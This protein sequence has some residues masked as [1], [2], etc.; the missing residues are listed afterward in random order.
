[1]T[2]VEARAAAGSGE[3]LRSR[4]AQRLARARQ[5]GS[6]PAI[7]RRPDPDAPV[8]LSGS[9][10]GMWFA[11]QYEPESPAYNVPTGLRLR[12]PLDPESLCGAV[13][14]LVGRH[15][16]LRSVVESSGGAPVCVPRPAGELRV[17]VVDL[18]TQECPEA[19]VRDRLARCG[20]EPFALDRDLPTRAVLYRLADDDHLLALTFH[21]IA[22]DAWS[23][24]LI[25]TDL[26]A[27]YAVRTGAAAAVPPAPLQYAD[28]LDWERRRAD[29]ARS[30]ATLNWWRERLAGLPAVLPLPADRPRPAVAESAGDRVPVEL[31]AEFADR[32]RRAAAETGSTPFM[33]LLAAW[34]A[35]LARLAGTDD[36]AVGMISAGRRHPE[37]EPV[38]GCFVR[39]VP[40]RAELSGEP[41][42]RELLARTRTAVL[43][44]I[45]H[46]DVSLE[47]LLTE[48]RPERVAGAHPLFQTLVNVYDDPLGAVRLPGLRTEAVELDT[49]TAKLD[50]SLNVVDPGPGRPLPGWLG[51]RSALFDRSTVRALVGWFTALLGGLVADLDR[52]VPAVPLAPVPG[53]LLTGPEPAW[54]DDATTLTALV[55]RRIAERPAAPAV[56]GPDGVLSYAELD[57]RAELLARRLRTAGVG[58]DEPVAVWVERSTDL[59]VGLL[60]ALRA[61]AAYL[62]LDPGYPTARVRAMLA[63]VRGRVVVTQPEL[64]ARLADDPGGAAGAGL[65]SV[66]LVD[67]A[68]DGPAPDSPVPPGPAL[69]A[70]PAGSADGT[71]AVGTTDEADRLAYVIFTSGST[72]TPKG[73]AVSHRS[74]VHYL[75]AV[76][77]RL[78]PPASGGASFALVSTPAADLGLTCL[79]GALVTGGTLHLVDRE[80]SLDP[81]ALAGYLGRHRVDVLKLVP[82]Q[83]RLLDAHGD[84]AGVLPGRLLV[85]AGEACP[86]ELVARVRAARPDLAVQSH[87]GPT[88]TT[89]AVLACDPDEVPESRRDG[90]LPLGRPLAGARLYV[91][92]RAGRPLPAGVPGEL[93]V[94]GPGV[95]RGYLHRP[96]A[97]AASFVP[98]PVHGRERCY[99]TGDRVRIRPDGTVDFLGRVDDQVKIRGYRVEPGEVAAACRA[100]P[101]VADAYVLPVGEEPRRQLAAWLVRRPDAE[102]DVATVRTALHGQL[103]DHLI[104]TAYVVLDA[105]PLN[106]N[107]KVDRAALPAPVAAGHTPLTGDTQHRI[108]AVWTGLLGAGRVGADDDF[109]ALG[110]DSFTAVRAARAI[111][112]RLRVI[113]LFTHR[114]VALLAR[115]LDGLDGGAEAGLLHRLAGPPPGTATT[116]TAVCVPYGGGSAAALQPFA[117][118]LAT[119][120]PGTQVYAVELPGHDPARPDEPLLPLPDLVRRCAAELD[121]IPGPLLV[122]GHCVGTAAALA[123]AQRLERDGREVVGL[124]LGA[125]FPMARLPGRLSRWIGR[126]FPTDR[127]FS[128]RAYRNFLTVMGGLEDV[129]DTPE[130]AADT[131]TMLRALRHDARDA[132]AWFSDRLGDPDAPRLRAPVLAVVGERDRSTELYAERYREWGAF[133]E[134]VELATIPRAGHYFLKHQAAGLGDLVAARLRAWGTGELPAAG[135]AE[136]LARAETRRNLRA[137]GLLAGGQFVSMVGSQL[138][139]FALGVWVY[140]QTGRL[141]DFAMITM[142]ALVPAVFAAPIGGAVTDRFDRRRV[143]LGADL[144][145][146]VAMGALALQ[147]W[148]GELRIWQVMLAVTVGSLATAVQRPAYLAATAQLVPKPYLPQANALANLGTGVGTLL[149]PLAGGVLITALG[150]PGVV[151]LDV[152]CFLVAVGTL[153]VVRFPD[154]LFRRREETF[155]RALAGGWRFIARRRPMIVMIVF[156]VPVNYLLAVAMVLVTPLVLD[157]GSP[158]TLGLVTGIGGLGAAVGAL[159]MVVWGGTRRL[160]VGMV[161]FTVPVGLG[162]VLMGVRPEPAL[163][164]AGLFLYWA[165]LSIL[166]AHWI[167]IIQV[168]VVQDLQGRVLAVNQML[169]AA[170]MPLGFVTAPAIA[171]RVVDPVVPGGAGRAIAVL[172]V[173]T[174]ALLMLWSTAGL[175]YR[176]LRRL[177]DDLPDGVAGA[178]IDDDLDALQRDF[179]ARPT[180]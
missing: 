68:A 128:D 178:E 177:E 44:A 73:V 163:V 141:L 160:A 65:L 172:L 169:A 120:H 77:D 143:M 109:F 7:P 4:L 142:L 98:D 33:V 49:P 114:T 97:T 145:G 168:K 123:L 74:I 34:Q 121:A 35:L 167:S 8:P 31:P 171:E 48:V 63:A 24:R 82:S 85:L 43:D 132:E 90:N 150:L 131:A 67:G 173:C 101:G 88:E 1:M 179:D 16:V 155:G 62:P 18:S 55:E 124:V 56:V 23:L 59:V 125:S 111:D 15:A 60:G 149:G 20:A 86:W 146:A 94:G 28:V 45:E 40:V 116:L 12:G 47:E 95:A 69:P 180:R 5:A 170:M 53:P 134:R 61:G 79:L 119:A 19:V 136:L 112:P 104:P 147:L 115:Y 158:A 127:W 76:L 81:A 130:A 105:L 126:L 166:N 159:A 129:A 103:P 3:E 66:V 157:F 11:A 26:A 139:A 110:G 32:V 14:D 118:A 13:V 96:E 99:R 64:A 30:A 91:V 70:E 83:L 156:Y 72:G 138:S 162:T 25:V 51:Y 174:G 17:E 93:V 38:V 84:L 41:T 29:P 6:A 27:C 161:G 50:L 153:L 113:D 154:R 175:A 39:T 57:R 92:D 37:T 148:L 22:V 107:G 52:P 100:V 46:A 140:Q 135:G 164:A 10:T 176:P 108:A 42:G 87:Y 144:A 21:H 78:G 122:Y 102:L 133:A 151:A 9:Q 165:S 71:G 36:L 75:R 137:F 2:G 117:E 58:A 80:T 89:V 54:T 106:P 152:A